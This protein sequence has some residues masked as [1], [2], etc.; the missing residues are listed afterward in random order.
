M[1]KLTPYRGRFAPSPSGELHFGSLIAAVASYLQARSSNGE[2]LI[3]IEDI[4]ENRT[5]KQSDLHILRTLEQFGF[6]WDSEVIYQSQRK[7]LYQD[8][9]DVL[10]EQ[11]LIFA[12]ECSR[13]Q[14]RQHAEKHGQTL[15]YPGTCRNR[16]LSIQKPYALRCRISD[17][18]LSFTDQIQ[19]K[20]TVNLA[21]DCGDFIV[22][23]RDGFFAYQ[24]VV[25]I[26]D[27]EQGITDIVRG[28]D[29]LDSTPQQI[30]LQQCLILPRLTY[31]HLPIAMHN[32]GKKL[33]KSHQD[34]AVRHQSQGQILSSVLDYLE[35]SPPTD[36]ALNSIADIWTWAIENWDLRKIKA[37]EEII[38]K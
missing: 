5:V 2:W 11:D 35:Q 21:R 30:Y 25:V 23:R 7:K 22:K 27:A 10:I 13:N 33:S 9:L 26:D 16:Q 20:L 29:L 14:L 36:L 37:V 8:Y 1:N 4:D 38:I 3:R 15:A 24:L 17:Q 32:N 31:A 28:A 6:E 34:L 18:K 12:C 19:G